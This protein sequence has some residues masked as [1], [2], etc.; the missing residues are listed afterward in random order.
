MQK[1][2]EKQSCMQTKMLSLKRPCVSIGPACIASIKKCTA[3]RD[4]LQYLIQISSAPTW[5]QHQSRSSTT[6]SFAD[7]DALVIHPH[8]QDKVQLQRSSCQQQEAT[9]RIKRPEFPRRAMLFIDNAVSPSTGSN[10]TRTSK[11]D[12]IRSEKF[13]NQLLRWQALSL[14]IVA[15]RAASCSS[16]LCTC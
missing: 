16:Q 10:H 7:S 12:F 11:L 2:R 1:E 5:L 15:D 8:W 6:I 13:W 3:K 14:K 9:W 4:Y